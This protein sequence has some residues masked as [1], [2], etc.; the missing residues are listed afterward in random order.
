M[1]RFQRLGKFPVNKPGFSNFDFSEDGLHLLKNT[2]CFIS[3]LKI[4]ICNSVQ[5]IVWAQAMGMINQP[6]LTMC[7]IEK[8]KLST[9]VKSEC[10]SWNAKT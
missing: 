5:N 7:Q 4:G 10:Y 2:D 6:L 3:F 8:E 1:T 9:L